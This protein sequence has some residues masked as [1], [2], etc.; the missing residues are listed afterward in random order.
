M[1]T[2]RALLGRDADIVFSLKPSDHLS[3]RLL[4]R[5]LGR[6][7]ESIQEQMESGVYNILW[8]DSADRAV[9]IATRAR[10]SKSIMSV[11]KSSWEEISRGTSLR[12]ALRIAIA[13]HYSHIFA[14]GRL[15][16]LTTRVA[17]RRAGE[18]NAPRAGVSNNALQTNSATGGRNTPHDDDF[19]EAAFREDP[20]GIRELMWHASQVIY[21]QRRH[22]FNT[23]HEPLSVFLAGLSLWAFLKYFDPES[24]DV[25]TGISVQLDEPSFCSPPETRK[26]IKDWIE[27]GG[28][29]YLE[30]VGDVRS[31]GAPKRILT[32]C[33]NMTR[34]LQVWRMASKVSE[35]FSRLLQREDQDYGENAPL[36][37]NR[38]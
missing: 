7:L 5:C 28:K 13:A 22:P 23:P 24:G 2:L 15:T 34:R 10:I 27:R 21:L 31:P 8:E 36:R 26:A 9:T 17:R 1:Q 37:A 20:R 38:T 12:V 16:D 3:K 35:I 6:C 30:G 29:T 33:V 14:A 4:L 32:L 19:I 18:Q 25:Q 11:Y